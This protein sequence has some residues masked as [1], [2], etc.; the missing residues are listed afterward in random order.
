MISV[1]PELPQVAHSDVAGSGNPLTCL[2]TKTPW[3]VKRL[4]VLRRPLPP[5]SERP[6]SAYRGPGVPDEDRRQQGLT[7][8]W[9]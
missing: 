1:V 2:S 8:W 3:A 5:G 6:E 4:T 9:R 7:T